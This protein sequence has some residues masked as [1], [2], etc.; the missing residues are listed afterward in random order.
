MGRPADARTYWERYLVVA[1]KGEEL[2]DSARVQRWLSNPPE[3]R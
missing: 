1:P 2:S 3:S